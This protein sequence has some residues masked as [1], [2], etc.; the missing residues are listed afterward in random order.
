MSSSEKNTKPLV[1]VDWTGTEGKTPFYVPP[2]DIQGG[3]YAVA[4]DSGVS[5]YDQLLSS[6]NDVYQSS[7]VLSGTIKILEFYNIIDSRNGPIESAVPTS[8]YYQMVYGSAGTLATIP[9]Y[10]QSPEI[11]VSG[12]YIPTRPNENIKVLVTIPEEDSNSGFSFSSLGH[13]F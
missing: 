3:Y 9:G 6:F 10:G 8:H 1:N 7:P 13:Y 11:A 5:Q 12:T 4:V 2:T